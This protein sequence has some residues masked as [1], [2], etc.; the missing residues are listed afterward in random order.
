MKHADKVHPEVGAS[1]SPFP[2]WQRSEFIYSLLSKLVVWGSIF[3]ILYL[4]RSFSLLIFLIF[5]FCYIQ[6]NAVQK[7]KP[8]IQNRTARVILVA[9][10]FLTLFL[11]AMAIL[12]PQIRD[13][14]IS[15][16]NNF[17]E[18]AQATDKQLELLLENYP[19]LAKILPEEELIP[20]IHTDDWSF[21]GSTLARVVQPLLESGGDGGKESLLSVFS[22]VGDIGTTLLGISSQFVLSLLFSFLIVLDLPNLKKGAIN[23]QRTRLKYF[24]DEVADSLVSFG[25]TLGRAFEAQF[26]V[27]IVNTILTA[28]GIWFLDIRD[29]IAFLS[30]IV[31]LCGFIPIAG[32]FISSVPICLIALAKGGLPSMLLAVALISFVHAVESY[33]LNPRIFGTHLRL[34]PVVVMILMTVSGKLFGVWGLVLCLP[35][36]TYIFRDAI[37]LKEL[38]DDEEPAPVLT[39]GAESEAPETETKSATQPKAESS[40]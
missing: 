1:S 38:P 7:I 25:L 14:S 2:P 20:D 3:G 31:F 10:S 21:S 26:I 34:N 8:W 6:S 22:T 13:Q 19:L 32:V 5:I 15:I 18:Y 9:L 27:S 11:V 35:I 17:E 16:T 30:L 4:L 37:Q 33:I 29:E 28:G 23:L 36:T 12:V 24:Y 40:T 39:A